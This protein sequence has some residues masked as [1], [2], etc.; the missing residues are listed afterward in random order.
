MIKTKGFSLVEILLVISI[1]SILIGIIVQIT[2]IYE[3]FNREW[4]FLS[5]T[6]L[7]AKE[8]ALHLETE[9]STSNKL[10]IESASNIDKIKLDNRVFEL[11]KNHPKKIKE[12]IYS[13]PYS[14]IEKI[15]EKQI[16]DEIYWKIEY[17]NLNTRGQSL[18]YVYGISFYV[19][20][21][22][23]RKSRNQTVRKLV[24]FI[25]IYRK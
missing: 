5:S 22:Y 1:F 16:K 7:D 14:I 6:A 17:E 13:T 3:K 12:I 9:M 25:V 24:Y 15:K 4:G 21:R 8:I 19:Y 11:H 2:L 10:E 20:N 18:G 23:S